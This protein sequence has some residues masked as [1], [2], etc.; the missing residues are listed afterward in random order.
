MSLIASEPEEGPEAVPP[1]DPIGDLLGSRVC[2]RRHRFGSL[3]LELERGRSPRLA[4]SRYYWNLEPPTVVDYRT[5]LRFGRVEV[6]GKQAYFAARGIRYLLCADEWD[7]DVLAAQLGAVAET[8]PVETQ[9]PI[10][11]AR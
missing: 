3:Y 6:E 4:V 10:V 2:S 8:G 7:V 1:P 5:E 11:A 9:L